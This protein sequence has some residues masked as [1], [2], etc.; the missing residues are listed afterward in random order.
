MEFCRDNQL[1]CVDANAA[2]RDEK[3][4]LP[5]E[6]SNDGYIHLNDAG[7]ARLIG[8]LQDFARQEMSES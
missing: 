2:V 1:D 4:H 5:A 7:A 3:G 6:Y 8:A